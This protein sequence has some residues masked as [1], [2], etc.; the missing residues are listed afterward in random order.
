M[1]ISFLERLRCP[2]C[3]GRLDRRADRERGGDIEEGS[4]R[5]AGCGHEYPITRSIPRF[6]PAS[7]Y[8][9]SFGLQWNAFR[10]TQLDS[11]T[12]LTITRDRFFAATAFPGAGLDGKWM[13]DVGCGAGRFAEVALSTGANVVAVDYSSAVDACHANLGGNE[14]LHVVQADVYRLP[15]ERPS[16]D[17]VYCLGVLQHTPDVHRAFSALPR[18]VKSGGRLAVDVYPAM[19]RNLLWSKYWLRPLTKRMPRNLLFR[20]VQFYVPLLLPVSTAI[21]FFPLGKKLRYLLPVANYHGVY[22]LSRDQLREWAILDTFDGLAPE[23]DHPQT[24]ATL[25][26]WMQEGGLREV[27]VFRA[28]HLVGRGRIE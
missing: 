18:E 6:V 22:P 9:D 10:R 26:E 19:L 4:L 16:F 11:H 25:R 20:L 15:F 17:Y 24:A 27:E 7:N 8:A 14:R 1:R 13:L 28:G 21:G 23:H 2:D 12:G 3:G 5:C